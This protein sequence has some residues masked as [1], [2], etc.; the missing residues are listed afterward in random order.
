MP[1]TRDI[2]AYPDRDALEAVRE[3]LAI[4]IGAT[5]AAGFKVKRGSVCG[6][7]AASGKLRR[8]SRTTAAGTGFAVDSNVGEVT[9]ASVFVAGD[10][11]KNAAGSVIGTIAAGGVDP[12]A[13]TVTLT[14]NAAVAVA[15]GAAVLGSDGSQ[16]AKAIAGDESDGVGDNGIGIYIG[17]PLKEAKL[18][19][20]DATAKAELGGVSTVGGI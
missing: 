16:T 18:L 5:V 11:L 3:D 6:E 1:P 14:G 2:A 19:D 20:L 17:G 9:D 8:R 15:A 12:V 13:N 4:I 7:I 10:V